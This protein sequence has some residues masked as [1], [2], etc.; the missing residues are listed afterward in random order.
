M[1][2]LKLPAEPAEEGLE[3]H[4]V[5][6]PSPRVR[7]RRAAVSAEV[8]NGTETFVPRVIPKSTEVRLRG[9]HV[10]CRS[11]EPTWAA[12]AVE[13]IAGA[14]SGSFLFSALDKTQ[15]R[16]VIDSMEERKVV[17]GDTVIKQGG[18][19]RGRWL[20]SRTRSGACA[21][22]EGDGFYIIEHGTFD[23][24]KTVW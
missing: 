7:G 20:V 9:L 14:I 3:K 8:D 1:P 19:H 22:S 16:A 17:K 24:L 23:V 18:Q 5:K 12:Q 13:R 10:V 15:L 11:A 21:G 2:G 4:E 6:L